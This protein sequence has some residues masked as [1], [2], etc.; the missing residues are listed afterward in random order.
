MSSASGLAYGDLIDLIIGIAFIIV[1]LRMLYEGLLG[2]T[3]PPPAGS[4]MPGNSIG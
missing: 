2:K 3:P 1:S 4:E